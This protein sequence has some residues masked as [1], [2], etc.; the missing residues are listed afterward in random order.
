MKYDITKE[1][2]LYLAARGQIILLACPGSGKTT[3]IVKKLFDLQQE[4]FDKYSP[5]SGVACLSFTNSAKDEILNKFKELHGVQFKFPNIVSTIDSFIFNYIT[6][7][8]WSSFQGRKEQLTIVDDKKVIDSI[9]KHNYTDKEGN[10][11]EGY[12]RNLLKYRDYLYRYP[13]HEIWKEKGGYSYAG[14]IVHDKTFQEYGEAIFDLKIEKGIITSLDSS[15]LA[16]YLMEHNRN[17]GKYLVK[18]FPYII[19]DEAQ[20][21]SEIQHLIFDKLVNCGIEHIEFVGDPYQ[22]IYEWRNAK[23]KLLNE[24]ARS[25][26]WQTLELTENRRSV[27]RIIDCFS[28]LRRK[29]DS[30]IS[31]LG[32][33]DNQIPITIYKYNSNNINTVLD[34]FETKCKKHNLK[35]FLVVVRGNSLKEK[36]LGVSLRIEPWKSPLPYSILSVLTLLQNKQ[37]KQAIDELR[38]TILELKYPTLTLKERNILLQECKLDTNFSAKL[39]AFIKNVPFSNISFNEWTEATE[40]LLKEKFELHDKP[41]FLFKS[42]LTGFTMKNLRNEIMSKYFDNVLENENK[43]DVTTIHQIKGMTLDAILVFLT[44]PNNVN[45]ISF[46]DIETPQEFPSEK[47]RLIYVACS[48]PKYF[49]AIAIDDSITDEDIINKFGQNIIIETL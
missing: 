21:T 44:E 6:L 31:S 22:S 23:P 11:K 2:E 47:Q 13:P 19:I 41:N 29:E 39:Y 46:K 35:D 12:S 33:E 32:V 4:C 5:Y 20:D 7:P 28:I 9:F 17:I 3:S 48:R 16:L 25:K 30:K 14:K 34:R 43:R 18:R 36:L 15:Y 1:R 10:R 24:K 40:T 27:Q 49:L 38:K 37:V 8:F 42:K 26:D 45:S